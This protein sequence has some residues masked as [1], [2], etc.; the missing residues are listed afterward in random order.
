MSISSN[1]S[2]EA[3][4]GRESLFRRKLSQLRTTGEIKRMSANNKQ[5]GFKEIEQSL[6]LNNLNSNWLNSDPRQL[7]KLALLDAVT[8]LYN[9]DTISRMFKDE[10]KRALRYKKALA[11]LIINLDCL[12]QVTKYG[13]P[14]AYDSVLK[15]T[16]Q[17]LMQMI[18]DVDI[19]GRY[20]R[21]H[22]LIVCPETTAEGA[23]CL[24][25]RL[26]QQIGS[27]RSSDISQSW[28]ISLS[29]GIAAFPSQ[30]QNDEQMLKFAFK[31]LK[32]ALQS[33]GNRVN[34]VQ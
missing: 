17:S 29:I 31:A 2:E 27:Q 4:V 9:H 16:A 12:E 20:D 24:A 18:R 23:S 10:V 19:P 11:L 28:H 5:A 32:S 33:G 22:L 13:G 7:E 25:E 8:E 30:A 21:E 34:L 1:Y 6:Y 15:R 14:V 3:V 26:C